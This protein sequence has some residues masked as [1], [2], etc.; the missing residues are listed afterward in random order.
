[1][2]R[3]PAAESPTALADSRPRARPSAQQQPG[4]PGHAPGAGQRRTARRPAE[5]AVPATKASQRHRGA[6]RA[7][8]RRDADDLD[9]YIQEMI[10]S[11]P[12]LTSE[13]R[14]K[15]ALLLHSHRR[16]R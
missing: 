15:L 14:D 5:P 3:R 16:T 13:Q 10:A 11:A 1:M 12:P 7:A 4:H 6:D 9:T 8:P 2:T